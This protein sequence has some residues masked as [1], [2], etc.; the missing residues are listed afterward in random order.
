MTNRDLIKE[1]KNGATKGVASHLYIKGDELINYSTV[2][3]YRKD[4]KFYL[5]SR[6]YSQSTSKIQNYCREILD[7]AEEYEDENH[8]YYW[9]AG[10]MGAPQIR[11]KDVY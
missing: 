8:C 4:G 5:N 2:I 1:F 6:K 11:A 3:A 7:I 10:Y 9:N